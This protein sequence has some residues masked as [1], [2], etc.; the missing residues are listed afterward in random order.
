M[1]RRFWTLARGCHAERIGIVP[2]V[3][4]T[5]DLS[6]RF[7]KPRSYLDLLLHP[8]R[9]RHITALE[10]VTLRVQQGEVFG[11]LGPN[12][13]G[14]TTLIKILCTLVLPSSGTAL[15]N[16]CNVDGDGRKIR[17]Q[18]G[19]VISEER[20][21]YWRLTGRQN[22]R[23]FATLNN[24]S[25][26]TASTRIGEAVELTGL[27]DEIDRTFKEY[28]SGT[29]QKLAI[30]RGLLTQPEILFLDEPTRNLDPIVSRNVRQFIR[31]Q[32]AADGARTVILATNNM[33]E[34]EEL[35]GRVAILHH[36]RVRMCES[37]E[38]IRKVIHGA[39]KYV[40]RLH[41]ERAETERRVLAVPSLGAT[42]SVIPDPAGEGLLAL[43]IHVTDEK[44]SISNIIEEI[45][46]AGIK[47]ETCCA[48]ESTLD[49]AFTK[50]LE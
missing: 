19:Y 41:G 26:A 27:E 32:I 9:T 31:E 16:G 5:I 40:L 8:F 6:R 33:R 24:L 39:H 29:K 44:E 37:V 49:E 36:G 20:S 18:I 43:R 45:V 22:L 38:R 50:V 25:P 1:A 23:F 3:I 30:A 4:E 28:S 2:C 13:A 42:A 48:E 7:A 15:V 12:G 17:K 46:H 14:K 21:F 47:I 34:A 35:C 11:I 10:Q